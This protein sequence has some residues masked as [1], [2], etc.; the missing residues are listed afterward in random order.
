MGWA[1]VD[2]LTF[3]VGRQENPFFATEMFWGPDEAPNGLVERIDFDRLLGWRSAGGEPVAYSKEGKSTLVPAP[4][5]GGSPFELSLIAGQF[6]SQ[7]RDTLAVRSGELS[8]ID[9]RQKI[10]FHVDNRPQL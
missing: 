7:F 9:V 8:L 4:A 3:V 5:P 10:A 2:G 6:I 1:P